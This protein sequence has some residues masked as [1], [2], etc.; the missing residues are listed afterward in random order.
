[1]KSDELAKLPQAH[2][3]PHQQAHPGQPSIQRAAADKVYSKEE[4]R[5]AA[6]KK[7]EDKRKAAEQKTIEAAEKRKLREKEKGPKARKLIDGPKP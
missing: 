5:A 6:V 2:P 1:V 3:Q 7:A 4:K